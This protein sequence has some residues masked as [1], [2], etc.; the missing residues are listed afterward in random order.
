MINLVVQVLRT[1]RAG[2]HPALVA[3]DYLRRPRAMIDSLPLLSRGGIE[4]SRD[5][6]S[7]RWEQIWP[8]TDS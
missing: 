2:S 7:L 5:I 6:G 4:S 3:K 1:E 8:K